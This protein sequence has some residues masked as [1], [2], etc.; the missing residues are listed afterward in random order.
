AVKLLMQNMP[1][2]QQIHLDWQVLAFSAGISIFSGIAFG[3]AP[4]FKTARPELQQALVAASRRSTGEHHATQRALVVAEIAVALVLLTG[5]GLMLRTLDRLWR[6]DPGFD[7]HNVLAFGVILP[8][9]MADAKPAALRQALQRVHEVMAETPGVEAVS[10]RNGAVPLAGDD[11]LLFWMAGQPQPH[12]DA[13][14]N[15]A[16]RYIVEPDYLKVMRIPLRRGR[17][18]GAQDT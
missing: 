5:A 17:F 13:E 7:P 6:V 15:W 3:L 8:P 14:K 1:R 4:A 2:T 11:E 12:S 10:L 9:S 18:F 16:I